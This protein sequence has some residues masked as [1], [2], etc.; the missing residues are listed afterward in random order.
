[1]GLVEAWG[2]NPI[3]WVL[4]HLIETPWNIIQALINPSLW[5]DWSNPE[6]VMRFVYYGAS[7]ELFF[8]FLLLFMV[9]TAVGLARP[10]AMWAM[11]RGSEAFQNATG[12]LFA[13]VGLLMVIQQIV[14]IFMQRVFGA[15]QI[16]VG[17]G[18]VATFDISWWSEELKLY[19][20]IVVCLCI[21]YTF[22]QGGHVRVDLFYSPARFRTKKVLDMF[23]ALAFMIPTATLVWLYGWFFL[24]RN[25][26]TPSTSAGDEFDRMMQKARAMRWNVETIGF[27]P[28]GFNAYFLFKVLLIALTGVIFLMAVT[29]FWR[30]IQEWREGQAADGR[31]VDKDPPADA[32]AEHAATN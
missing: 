5:L 24:W 17:F 29:M 14:I 1:M 21:A 30:S 6:S 10:A 23:G 27:S 31:F 9:L 26:I 32:A 19:N 12:R 16:S 4:A 2:G 13:W 7:V 8:V 20:A 18:K 22:V 3:G 25:L 28:N 11:V 15:S